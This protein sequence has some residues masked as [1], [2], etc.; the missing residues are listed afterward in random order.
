M[1][2]IKKC[3]QRKHLQYRYNQCATQ[4]PTAN[5][6]STSIFKY[7]TGTRKYKYVTENTSIR[8]V[9]GAFPGYC[10]GGNRGVGLLTCTLFP[11]QVLCVLVFLLVG[12]AASFLV[13]AMVHSLPAS[14]SFCRIMPALLFWPVATALVP[15]ACPSLPCAVTLSPRLLSFA[16]CRP[17]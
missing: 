16:E 5:T 13:A 12:P 15:G 3:E 17:Q 10:P 14:R 1:Q 6:I 2:T 9:D 4:E 11:A 8:S 7:N